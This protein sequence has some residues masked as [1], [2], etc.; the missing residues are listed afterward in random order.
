MHEREKWKWSHSVL[1]DSYWP[2][3][4]QP[5]RLLCPW[6][7]PGKSTGVGCHCLLRQLL[8]VVDKEVQMLNQ[9]KDAYLLVSRENSERSQDGG[10]MCLWKNRQKHPFRE[11]LPLDFLEAQRILIPVHDS[12]SDSCLFWYQPWKNYSLPSVWGKKNWGARL[13]PVGADTFPPTTNKGS[14]LRADPNWLKDEGLTLY[15]PGCL[16]YLKPCIKTVLWLKMTWEL[17]IFWKQNH[18]YYSYFHS[19]DWRRISYCDSSFYVSTWLDYGAQL[20]DQ[21]PVWRL[22]W[23]IFLMEQT[24]SGFP[25]GS[26]DKE[27]ACIAGD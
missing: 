1:S 22:L 8:L 14:L 21:T 7:F 13:G 24:K 3:G 16:D 26:E 9:R 2:H 11:R 20:F 19:R 18:D 25:G 5:T 23:G 17:F 15:G 10:G 27:S 6:D 4:L 12:I